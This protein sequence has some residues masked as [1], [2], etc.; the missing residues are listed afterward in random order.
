[1]ESTNTNAYQ[2]AIDE[3]VTDLDETV[4]LL[5]QTTAVL[6]R[7]RAL[8]LPSEIREGGNR[9]DLKEP[10]IYTS[11]LRSLRAHG[12]GHAQFGRDPEG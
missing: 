4:R 7:I 10:R 5:R 1:M 12:G 8:T 9:S 3:F 11:A 6:A 2:D